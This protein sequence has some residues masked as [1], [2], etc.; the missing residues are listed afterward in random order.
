MT[1]LAEREVRRILKTIVVLGKNSAEFEDE[2]IPDVI[3]VEDDEPIQKKTKS[4][5]GLFGKKTKTARTSEIVA[6]AACTPEDLSKDM[7][8]MSDPVLCSTVFP[9]RRANNLN[10]QTPNLFN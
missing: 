9:T 1:S 2:D 3:F 8:V 10:F 6:E 4:F 5:K 7:S